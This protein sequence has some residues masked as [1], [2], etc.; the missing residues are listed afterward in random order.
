MTKRHVP[1]GCL[2]STSEVWPD[3]STASPS[4]PATRKVPIGERK[5]QI[6]CF[7]DPPDLGGKHR[8]SPSS[9]EKSFSEK[10]SGC[11]VL[12]LLLYPSS[13]C[14]PTTWRD[15]GDWED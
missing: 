8:L 11:A 7:K 2:R 5:D 15:K 6:V 10:L 1:S 3:I 4:G 9:Q 14:L 12:R 13:S